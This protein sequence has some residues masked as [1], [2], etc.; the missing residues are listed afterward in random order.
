MLQAIVTD[1]DIAMIFV[2]QD[3][4]RTRTVRPNDDR[5]WRIPG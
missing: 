4:C 5:T 3:L 2:H 1:N